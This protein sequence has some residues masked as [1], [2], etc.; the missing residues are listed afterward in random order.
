MTDWTQ[1]LQRRMDIKGGRPCLRGTGVPVDIVADRFAAGEG[2]GDIA[3][4]YEAAPSDHLA[5]QQRV[6]AALRFV[7]AVRGTSLT[8]L[9]AERKINRLLPLEPAPLGPRCALKL[10]HAGQHLWINTK[11]RAA[12]PLL[13]DCIAQKTEP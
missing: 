2:V 6:V 12:M 7:L 5:M 11:R 13:S 3:T 1:H 9:R 10:G 8:S 4:D